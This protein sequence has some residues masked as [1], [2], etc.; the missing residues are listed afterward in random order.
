M[1]GWKDGDQ[2]G[3]FEIIADLKPMQES[4]R[5]ALIK[6][7]ILAAL[8]LL[9]I[10]LLTYGLVSRLAI[11]P[12]R[13]IRN[14]VTHVAKGD[15]TVAL[16][17]STQQDDI[18]QTLNATGEMVKELRSIV[19]RVT[20]ASG[21]VATGSISL[22]DSTQ[23][24]SQGATEQAAS[25]EETSSA[26][27][28]MTSN[29]QQNTDNA[30]QTE[31]IAQK[32]SNDAQEGG[33]AVS[34]AVKAMKEIAGK[35]GII[36]EIARQTN[37]LALNAAIEAARAG[38]HGK[39]FA[40]VAAEVRKLAERSQT[41]AGEITQLAGSS[42]DVAERA[43]TLLNQLVPDIQRTAELVQGI[44][45]A[46]REQTQGAS[47]I[48]SAIQQLDRVIQ[49]NAGAAEK[50]ASTANQ[51]SEQAQLLLN[52]IGFFRVDGIQRPATTPKRTPAAPALP[53]PTKSKTS[54]PATSSQVAR[55]ALPAPTTKPAARNN[56]GGVDLDLGGHGS[57]DDEFERF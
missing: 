31:T 45:V 13:A 1:E 27:E 41:A 38:D 24:I 4:V 35:I 7:S 2:R 30:Q 23:Q 22:N 15:L 36:E 48:N 56:A 34:A 19:H 50:M 10:G 52:A 46:S 3:A 14:L 32:A 44:S 18:G 47:Q 21:H 40:V 12:V 28:E 26:M 42:V 39:G 37:L 49:Q 43:G 25:I 54:K 16:P 51:L 57:S 5:D 53:A 55:R 33:D 9:G 17:H 11:Q 29:I 8:I 6:I 20:E